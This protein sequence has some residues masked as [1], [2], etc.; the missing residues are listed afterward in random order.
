MNIEIKVEKKTGD[1]NKDKE[2]STARIMSYYYPKWMAV[3][4]VF[5][6]IVNSFGF[7]VYGLIYAKLLFVMMVPKSPSF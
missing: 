4:G 2:I 6:S 7:P 3:F 5:V 1:D